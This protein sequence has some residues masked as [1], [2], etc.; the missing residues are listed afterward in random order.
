MDVDHKVLPDGQLILLFRVKE[1]NFV[2]R[3]R[4]VG[5]SREKPRDVLAEVRIEPGRFINQ[6][7]IDMKVRRLEAWYRRKG[8][9]HVQVK[10]ATHP[11]RTGGTEVVFSVDEGPKVRVRRI[12]FRGERTL[13]DGDLRDRMHTERSGFFGKGDFNREVLEADCVRLQE[14]Y[15]ERGFKGRHRHLA[16]PGLQ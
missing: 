9:E 3:V 16:R 5:V 2:E 14:Y 12:V 4:C 1:M 15:R 11:G 8:Y 13:T 10:A 6:N 7:D